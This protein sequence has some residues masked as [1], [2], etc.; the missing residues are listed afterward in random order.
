MRKIF[1]RFSRVALVPGR[2][3]VETLLF[4]IHE[5]GQDNCPTKHRHRSPLM[6]VGNAI[7][8]RLTK[9]PVATDMGETETLSA[10]WWAGTVNTQGSLTENFVLSAGCPVTV[11][12]NSAIEFSSLALHPLPSGL[13]RRRCSELVAMIQ[14]ASGVP[15]RIV[16][17]AFLSP[18]TSRACN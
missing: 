4:V 14:D 10:P 12:F 15:W 16:L 5:P 7:P 6:S 3:G 13:P 1:T 18:S 17:K 11:K 2:P 8:R 9:L